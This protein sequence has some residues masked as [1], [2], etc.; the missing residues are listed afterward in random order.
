MGPGAPPG[1]GPELSP[2][3]GGEKGKRKGK[4]RKERKEKNRKSKRGEEGEEDKKEGKCTE[5]PTPDRR[6]LP[7]TTVKPRAAPFCP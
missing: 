6:L 2:G 4:G 7:C 3:E 5:G 1:A